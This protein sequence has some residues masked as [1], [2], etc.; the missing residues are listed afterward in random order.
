MSTPPSRE[1]E[2]IAAAAAFPVSFAIFAL[3]RS[4]R[5]TA[6]SLLGELGLY[7]GQELILMQLWNR[8]GLSQKTLGHAQRI[9]H[10]TIAKS[11]RR[12]E[13]AGLVTRSRSGAD[14]RVALVSLTDA[15]RALEA[16]TLAV[17]AELERTT[18]AGL[19]E[20][21]RE[22]FAMLARKIAPNLD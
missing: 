20:R 17:W 21:E 2:D 15:G 12:L 1:P 13:L 14:G 19:D 8:D 16:R 7:P 22:Q 18:T 4:H 3:A 9:D 11:V 10:S 6:G 5:A